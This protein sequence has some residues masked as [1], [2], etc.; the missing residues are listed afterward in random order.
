MTTQSPEKR[1]VYVALGSNLGDSLAN[2]RSG[3]VQLQNLS[4]HPIRLSAPW[5]TSPV[6]CPPDASPFANAVAELQLKYELGAENVLDQCQAIEIA[7]GRRP[8]TIHNESRPLDLDLIAF[9]TETIQTPSLTVP[10]PRA[11][12]RFFV[13]A[14][15]EQLAPSLVL[16]G[17]IHSVSQLLAACRP[18]AGAQRID[19][20]DWR[21]SKNLGRN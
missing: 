18:D 5:I 3:A 1:L 19:A 16:P 10:H 8:K 11:H 4:E 7:H 14:P 9:G 6:D 2:L 12:E 13:L 15:L 17:Q 20:F 21:I